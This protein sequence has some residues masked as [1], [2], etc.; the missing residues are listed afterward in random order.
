MS[1]ALTDADVAAVVAFLSQERLE[2]FRQLTRSH[3]DAIDVH[4]IAM[5]LSSALMPVVGII[6]IALRNAV[7]AELQRCFAT[8]D[9]L[10]NPPPP[11]AWKGDEKAKTIQGQMSAKRAAYAKLSNSQKNALDAIAFPGGV[12]A[13]ISH[14]HHARCRQQAIVVTDGQVLAQLTLFFWKRLFSPDYEA[15]LWKR[16]LKNVFPNKRID[17]AVVSGHLEHLY[18]CRNRVAHHE[19]VYGQRL[20][21]ALNA[22]DFMANNF[23]SVTPRADTPLSKILDPYMPALARSAKTMGQALRGPTAAG[24][25]HP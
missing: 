5:Q 25:R 12:P 19:P 15:T 4:Q 17:R 1:R 21:E 6:E 8:P 22:I 9:W 16:G 3:R 10:M 14:E 24:S 13:N 20:S 2:Y 23:Q 18:V 11:F 7:S